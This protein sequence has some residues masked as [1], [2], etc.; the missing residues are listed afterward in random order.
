MK[1]LVD[2]AREAGEYSVYWDGC[3]EQR[4]QVSSGVYLYIMKVGS[5]AKTR[6]MV[7]LR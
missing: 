4:R 2:G 1:I 5:F 7:L 3:D 6:K